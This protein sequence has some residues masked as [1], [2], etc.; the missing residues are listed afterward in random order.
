MNKIAIKTLNVELIAYYGKMKLN[1]TI[2]QTRKTKKNNGLKI[3][4]EDDTDKFHINPYLEWCS[5]D[6]FRYHVGCCFGGQGCDFPE[7]NNN[8]RALAKDLDFVKW[9]KENILP[10]TELCIIN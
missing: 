1:V 5:N 4:I 3:K 9:F 6:K 7:F 8:L 10:V 2:Y